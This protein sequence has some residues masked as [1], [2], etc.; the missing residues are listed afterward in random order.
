VGADDEAAGEEGARVGFV[1]VMANPPVL[2]RFCGGSLLGSVGAV[3]VAGSGVCG[4]L[5]NED[6][7]RSSPS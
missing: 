1:R 2:R 5:G 6:L 3:V 4:A 7:R